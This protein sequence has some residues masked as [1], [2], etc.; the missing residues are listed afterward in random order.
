MH[1]LWRCLYL[2]FGALL[3]CDPVIFGGAHVQFVWTDEVVLLGLFGD[4]SL[5][6]DGRDV[7]E[8]SQIH[9]ELQGTQEMLDCYS[10]G[11]SIDTS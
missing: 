10:L 9:L 2:L 8:E 11:D 5:R 6:P 1:V 3:D 7:A 4:G